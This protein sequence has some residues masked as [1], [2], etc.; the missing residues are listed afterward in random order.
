MNHLDRIAERLR[1]GAQPRSEA[2][3]AIFTI[4]D[5]SKMDCRPQARTALIGVGNP[6]K[7]ISGAYLFSCKSTS[8]IRRSHTAHTSLFA[9]SPH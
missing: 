2:Q 6:D 1:S 5:N 9:A 8:A 7:S 3:C 4:T